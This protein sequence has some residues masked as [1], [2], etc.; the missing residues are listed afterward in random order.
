MPKGWP[1]QLGIGS[2]PSWSPDDKQIAFY[3][4]GLDGPQVAVQNLDGNGR[5]NLGRGKGPCW[6]PDGSLMVLMDGNNLM[7]FDMTSGESKLLFAEP[8]E[9]VLR[10]S[11]SVPTA[12]AWPL[13]R[14]SREIRCRTCCWSM[15]G[16]HAA[17]PRLKAKMH[18]CVSFSP[19]GKRL[20]VSVERALAD[21]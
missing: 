2:T 8:F 15:L 20:I 14:A 5:N 13:S 18:G 10:V 21:S 11:A 16:A 3:A 1:A 17:E 7:L 12:N 4:F 6:S 9:E 19:D